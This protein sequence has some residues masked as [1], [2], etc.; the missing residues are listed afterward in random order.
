MLLKPNEEIK[1]EITLIRYNTFDLIR[2]IFLILNNDETHQTPSAPSSIADSWELGYV[3]GQ[4]KVAGVT[5][6]ASECF[7]EQQ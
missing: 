4:S 2:S 6:R 5:F 7:C 1:L 3:S